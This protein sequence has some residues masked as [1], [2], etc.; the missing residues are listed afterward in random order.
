MS[1]PLRKKLASIFAEARADKSPGLPANQHLANL[2]PK[3]AAKINWYGKKNPPEPLGK[4]QFTNDPGA[5]ILDPSKT[6][7]YTPG[8]T[9]PMVTALRNQ[10]LKGTTP[11]AKIDWSKPNA[12]Q[13]Y[14]QRLAAEKNAQAQTQAAMMGSPKPHPKDIGMNQPMIY[15][16]RPGG[17]PDD[18]ESKMIPSS[19]QAVANI[20]KVLKQA[21]PEEMSY[22]KD[23]YRH[24][25]K[26]VAGLAQRYGVPIPVVAGIVAVLSPGL[27]PIENLNS[28][29]KVLARKFDQEIAAKNGDF[30][31]KAVSILGKW[32][33]RGEIKGPKV[34][35][36]WASIADPDA[37]QHRAVLDGH[38]FNIWRGQAVPIAGAA[39][40]DRWRTQM[41]QDY[42]KAG[43]QFGL[44]AQ[45]AQAVSWYVWRIMVQK[46]A[47][48][49]EFNIRTNFPK[50]NRQDMAAGM[51]PNIQSVTMSDPRYGAPP[52]FMKRTMESAEKTPAALI[53]EALKKN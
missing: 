12:S 17:S 39:I 50:P 41:E 26:M 13:L 6:P 8:V 2:D 53:R 28:A 29:E 27:S 14:Q 22:Q 25:H 42:A 48:I 47:V 21:T 23:W 33:I 1:E 52:A 49:D 3:N 51:T 5:G 11:A 20:V 34:S 4:E 38:A 44:S 30:L 32:D 16:M 46:D 9:A 36:F 15:N 24:M 43:K 37:V 19:E 7:G 35:L 45:E 31:A 18:P 40:P 10:L